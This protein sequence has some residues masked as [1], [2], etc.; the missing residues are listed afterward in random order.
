MASSERTIKINVDTTDAV[1][2]VKQLR[3]EAE[4]A[5]QSMDLVRGTPSWCLV[6]A[7]RWFVTLNALAFPCLV[8]LLALR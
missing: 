5:R 2:A 6:P 4:L 1:A 8:L 7:L 3:R